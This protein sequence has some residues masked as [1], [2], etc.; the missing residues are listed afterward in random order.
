MPKCLRH[1]CSCPNTE[2]VVFPHTSA[3]RVLHTF[4]D[5]WFRVNTHSQHALHA[6]DALMF[7][8]V[9]VD[10][11][12]GLLEEAH[13]NLVKRTPQAQEVAYAPFDHIRMQKH[14]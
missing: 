1:V 3:R 2:P 10:W 7:L 9:G 13:G 6:E 5:Q 14:R 11:G 8:Q 4:P 12:V